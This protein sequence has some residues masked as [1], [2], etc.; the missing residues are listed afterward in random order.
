MIH[1]ER[2]K[3]EDASFALQKGRSRRSIIVEVA[4]DD[5]RTQLEVEGSETLAEIRSK[6][7]EEM[8]ILAAD[9]DK[10]VVIG[11][12]RQPVND[13]RKVEDLLAEGQALCF[14]LLPQVAFGPRLQGD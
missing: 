7:L 6:A 3:A 8:E 9:P 5:R 4:C 10:Y 11:G 1:R 13:R 14:R 2:Q 12:D